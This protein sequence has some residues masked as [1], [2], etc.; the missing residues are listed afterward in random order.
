MAN[1][2]AKNTGVRPCGR[3]VD[4]P[5]SGVMSSSE[6]KLRCDENAAITPNTTSTAREM[7]ETTIANLKLI[8]APAAFSARNAPYR[9]AHHTQ[10]GSETPNRSDVIWSAYPAEKYTTTAVVIT[11]STVSARPVTNPPHG[12]IAARANEYA[13]PVCGIAALIS[14]MLNSI[15]PYITVTRTAA[16]MNP[17]QPACPMPKFQPEKSPETTAAMAMPHNPQNPALR[18]SCRLSKYPASA[19]A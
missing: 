13:P 2:R 7:I 14:P 18:C 16:S 11:Y 19:R 15:A 3:N 17:P 1:G 10:T 6:P 12:P 4:R 5:A 9:S 8:S